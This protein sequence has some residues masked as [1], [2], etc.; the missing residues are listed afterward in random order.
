[1]E[2]KTKMTRQKEEVSEKEGRRLLDLSE[3]AVKTL[4]RGAKKRGY[5]THGP[6]P[7]WWT[8]AELGSGY[9]I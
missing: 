5:V 2:S 1:M 9:P 4:M 7:I 6:A 3:A 8:V